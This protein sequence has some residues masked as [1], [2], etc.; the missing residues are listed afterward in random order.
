[1]LSRGLRTLCPGCPP[2]F[3]LLVTNSLLE[4]A[5]TR[6]LR[7]IGRVLPGLGQ[8]QLELFDLSPQLFDHLLLLLNNLVFRIHVDHCRGLLPYRNASFWGGRQRK[9]M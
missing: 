3:L 8:F 1:M 2:P 7:R 4:L 9:V 6:R 5:L